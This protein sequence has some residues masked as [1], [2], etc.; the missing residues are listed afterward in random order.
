M[1]AAGIRCTRSDFLIAIP[2]SCCLLLAATVGLIGEI[3]HVQG[4]APPE[5][6]ASTSS[7][8]TRPV[9]PLDG[10]RFSVEPSTLWKG[11]A[12]EASW[13]WQVCFPEPRPIGTILQ[14]HADHQY[15]LRNAPRDYAWQ[16]SEDGTKWVT[17]EETVTRG[18]RRTFRV[19]RLRQSRAVRWIRLAIS[20]ATGDCPTLREVAFFPDVSSEVSFPPWAI[21]VSTTGSDMLP[22]E[23]AESFRRLARSC[24]GWG[25]LQFQNVWLGD[26]NE[27][28]LSAEPRPLCA[29]LSG[30]FIDWCQQNREHWRGTAGVLRDRSLPMWASC[31]GAQGLAILAETG[32]DRPWDCP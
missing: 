22:G 4:E 24:Q 32:V 11:R 28:F 9:G 26:F 16:V 3:G 15:A 23:G 20:Q 31:G 10:E 2:F 30:N 21:V 17:L 14:I 7:P 6:S 13:W 18:E 8:G 27:G 5:L 29:F 1:S 19:H 12:G 25:D